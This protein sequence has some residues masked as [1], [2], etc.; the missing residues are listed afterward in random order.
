MK[1]TALLLALV[2]VIGC[3]NTSETKEETSTSKTTVDT[4]TAAAAKPAETPPPPMDSAAMMKAMQDYMT[5]GEMHKW[6]ASMNGKWDAQVI[7]WMK[8]PDKNPDTSKASGENKMVMGGRYQQTN[9]KGMMMGMPFEGLGMMGYDNAKQKFVNTWIDNMGTGIME[10]EGTYD[11]A[12][13]TLNM[14]GKSTDPMTKKDCDMRE[15][16]TMTD[17]KHQTLEMYGTQPG[18]KEMK[19]MEIHYTKK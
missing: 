16:F 14:S 6:M 2:A 4:T 7:S 15:V 9:F 5:P 19:M 18:Q 12:T 1:K 3:N 8:G 13:K 11:P 10:M 17:D